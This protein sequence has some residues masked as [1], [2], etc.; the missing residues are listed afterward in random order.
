MASLRYDDILPDYTRPLKK[1]PKVAVRSAAFIALILFSMVLGYFIAILPAELLIFPAIPSLVLVGL[2]LWALPDIGRVPKTVN[3]T[4]L[5]IFVAANFIWPAY[6]ALN[7]PGLPWLNPQ[8]I[9][10]LILLIGGLY[11]YSTSSVMRTQTLQAARSAPVIFK[12]FLVYLVAMTIALPL[13]GSQITFSI[14]KWANNQIY[15][16]FLFFVTAF[17]VSKTGGMITLAKGIMVAGLVTALI[18]IPE[19]IIERVPWVGYVPSWL[20]GDPLI[21]ERV[22]GS[23]ARLDFLGYRARASFGVS[24]SFAEFLSVP[25]P[26]FIHAAVRADGFVRKAL[27]TSAAV[28]IAYS[29]AILTGARSG[30]NGLIIGAFG[31]LAFWTY[32]RW[33]TRP[34]DMIGAAAVLSFPVAVVGFAVLTLFWRRLYVMVIGGGQHSFSNQAREVQ[35]NR[36]FEKLMQN[37]IGYGTDRAGTVIGYTNPGGEGTLDSGYINVLID[38]GIIGFAAFMTFAIAAIFKGLSLGMHSKDEELQ[39]A[40]PAAIA[41]AAILVIKSVLS[42][43]ENLPLLFI[44]G[45]AICGLA[46][47]AK[48]LSESKRFDEMVEKST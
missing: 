11:G 1:W 10:L 8:R 48:A 13:A 3:S 16:T 21:Y 29:M 41:V 47:R 23:Q 9:T 14:T 4:L 20:I 6:V 2:I 32:R 26:F 7:L 25:L 45:G 39:L 5:S 22:S 27:L 18:S 37:P 28:L 38:T 17:I 30:M 42:Q 43:Q 19:T 36:A 44:L 35:W 24:L 40:A 15:W 33:R 34:H 12:S 31:Y 46:Y